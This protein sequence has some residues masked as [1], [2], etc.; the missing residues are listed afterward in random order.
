MPTYVYVELNEDGSEGEPFEVFQK[1]SDPALT[2]HPQTG[3][4]VRRVITAPIIPG[5]G[6]DHATKKMLSNKNLNDLG[7]TK[8]ERAGGG[9]YEKK[10][11]KG[12]DVISAE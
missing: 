1:M 3:K 10:A 8:Y 9:H 6:S 11:G 7:F 2:T 4:P 12:P 5:H